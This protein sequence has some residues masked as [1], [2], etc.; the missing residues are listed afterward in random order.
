M[1]EQRQIEIEALCQGNA[2]ALAK[3]R[4]TS[5]NGMAVCAAVAKA[6]QIGAKFIEDDNAGSA[7]P[8]MLPG[9]IIQIGSARIEAQPPQQL[10]GA[11][12]V[13]EAGAHERGRDRDDVALAD[14]IADEDEVDEPAPVRVVAKSRRRK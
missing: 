3:V 13:I 7:T 4:D 1:R 6:E 14:D 5:E 10:A 8:P 11:R 12:P 9:L 2:A